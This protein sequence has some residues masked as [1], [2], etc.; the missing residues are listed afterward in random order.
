MTKQKKYTDTTALFRELMHCNANSTSPV[1]NCIHIE[2]IDH[3]HD[4]PE[5]R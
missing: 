1:P 2:R 5:T 3:Y 4:T